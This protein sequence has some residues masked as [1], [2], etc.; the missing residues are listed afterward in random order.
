MPMRSNNFMQTEATTPTPDNS[1][2][3]EENGIKFA[4]GHFVHI[5]EGEYH[6]PLMDNYDRNPLTLAIPPLGNEISVINEVATAPDWKREY[7]NRPAHRRALMPVAVKQY[8]NPVGLHYSLAQGI[9]Q[10]IS[11]GYSGRN[12]MK[13]TWDR[14]RKGRLASAKRHSHYTPAQIESA[15]LTGMSGVGKSVSVARILQKLI[16]QV[17]IHKKFEGQFFARPQIPWI[18]LSCPYDANAFQLA[19]QFL[20]E[21]DIALQ[22]AECKTA[23][24]DK[25]IKQGTSG[26]SA[27][28]AMWEVAL[29][30]HVGLVVIDEIQNLTALGLGGGGKLL[31]FVFQLQNML[32]VPVLLVGNGSIHYLA[33][34]SF[35][36]VRRTSFM[37]RPHWARF[38]RNS[39]EWETFLRTLWKYQYLIE[40]TPL[41]DSLSSTMYE[42][43]AGIPD[44]VGDLFRFAQEA[45]INE[46]NEVITPELLKNEAKLA[47]SEEARELVKAIQ[48]YAWEKLGRF[49]D[50]HISD[51]EHDNLTPE[52]YDAGRIKMSETRVKWESV[53]KSAKTRK[54]QRKVGS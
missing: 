17:I 44:L 24:H 34:E 23:L 39:N 42:L 26:V 16:P 46:N 12:P 38:Q 11:S 43:T 33:S 35:R 22:T 36:I 41:T 10:L 7:C 37:R 47:F 29:E 15:L 19:S 53:Q 4:R 32:G 30:T 1:V 31:N 45:C 20:R 52:Q 25:H 50:L 40:A 28:A 2:F 5:E 48:T 27:I 54:G 6:E 3:T 13:R 21:V 18:Y 51:F 9:H 49:E 8:F 14:D